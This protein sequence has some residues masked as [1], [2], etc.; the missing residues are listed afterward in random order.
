[1]A[2]KK[3]KSTSEVTEKSIKKTKVVSSKKTKLEGAAEKE[4]LDLTSQL[5]KV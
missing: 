3:N 1:M 4:K 5:A 2:G